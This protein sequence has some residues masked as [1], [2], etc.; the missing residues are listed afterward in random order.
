MRSLGAL[1]RSPLRHQPANQR[2]VTDS[3]SRSPA[4]RVWVV[5]VPTSLSHRSSANRCT[6]QAT[7]Q[8]IRYSN[9]PS[10]LYRNLY[11]T[12]LSPHL[13]I[14]CGN[15][16]QSCASRMLRSSCYT[17]CIRKRHRESSKQHCVNREYMSCMNTRANTSSCVACTEVSTYI[18][19]T[20]LDYRSAH[21]L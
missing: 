13:S 1:V 20:G 6:L 11:G 14:F 18:N 7:I 19:N 16:G 4:R 2:S 21:F 12:I 10:G 5:P 17:S 9:H 8:D 3:Y 15:R